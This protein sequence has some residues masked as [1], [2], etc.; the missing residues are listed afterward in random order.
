MNRLD[1]VIPLL[2]T[3]T[4][5]MSWCPVSLLLSQEPQGAVVIP[6]KGEKSD[7]AG[8]NS[9]TANNT[10]PRADVN[11]YIGPNGLYFVGEVSAKIVNC[12]IPMIS[13][14]SEKRWPEGYLSQTVIT[15]TGFTTKAEAT[16]T[17]PATK[18]SVNVKIGS[19]TILY[20][21]VDSATQITFGVQPDNDDPNE[22]AIIVVG[23]PP[24]TVTTTA[25]IVGCN[26]PKSESSS[27]DG[28]NGSVGKW[29][30]TLISSTNDSSTTFAGRRVAEVDAGG[31]DDSC[32][33]KG[34]PFHD[35]PG[36]PHLGG[37]FWIV[38]DDN[39]YGP[40]SI[41][42]KPEAVTWYRAHNI[43]D[44]GFTKYQQMQMSCDLPTDAT[45]HNYGSPPNTLGGAITAN[46][47][48]SSRKGPPVSEA[49]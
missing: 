15:G 24:H 20:V 40:D 34:L 8:S 25:Q 26:L 1:K 7:A 36:E 9:R 32:H 31:G 13:H 5:G 12:P 16:A 10:K 14:L 29:Q 2:V 47:V 37:F 44:C 38:R 39:T 17:C 21:D 23:A 18:L 3:L 30:Q 27:F 49:Y 11:S 42:Y 41:G 45:M 48:S 19:V 4:V 46:S 28:W 6:Y 33:V 35:P 22:Q 43:I